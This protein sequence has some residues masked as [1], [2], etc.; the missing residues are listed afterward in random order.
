MPGEHDV[1]LPELGSQWLQ[2]RLEWN[3]GAAALSLLEEIEAAITQLS[4]A[5]FDELREWMA[6]QLGNHRL[7][8]DIEAGLLDTRIDRALA[9]RQVGRTTQLRSNDNALR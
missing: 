1:C 4:P 7:E 9:D 5:E 8:A 2:P 3:W 6:E